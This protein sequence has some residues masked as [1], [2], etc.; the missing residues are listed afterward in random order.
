MTGGHIDPDRPG[1]AAPVVT[2]A[3][4]HDAFAALDEAQR[5]SIHAWTTELLESISREEV[6]AHRL[7]QNLRDRQHQLRSGRTGPIR[8]GPIQAIVLDPLLP[9]LA[10]EADRVARVGEILAATKPAP[11]LREIAPLLLALAGALS[12]L[13]LVAQT[14][15]LPTTVGLVIAGALCSTVLIPRRRGAYM[16]DASTLVL[17]PRYPTIT[18]ESALCLAE[19]IHTARGADSTT[20][21]ATRQGAGGEALSVAGNRQRAIDEVRA[22]IAEL[23]AAWLEYQLDL[24]AWYLT[25]PQLRNLND[26]VISDYRQAEADLR[27]NAAGLTDDA[28]HEQASTALTAARRALKA[29]GDANLHALK[30]GV[31][32]LT[33]SEDAALHRLYGLVGTLNDRSTPRAM[34]AELTTKISDTMA[35]LHATPCTL[36]DIAELPVIKAESRLLAIE[37]GPHSE[38]LNTGVAQ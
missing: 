35:K 3:P 4:V 26:P 1:A 36:A 6:Y 30:I 10:D 5:L 24:Q 8:T 27:D 25:K 22:A 11:I 31:S 19:A 32:D 13:M 33:A 17:T 16:R 15:I 18:R 29:W 37:Q 38:P 20:K 21:D 12:M 28:T 23:D 2:S 7:H 14:D 9:Y 34:W